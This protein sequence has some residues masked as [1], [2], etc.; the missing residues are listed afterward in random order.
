MSISDQTVPV[1]LRLPKDLYERVAHEA[2]QEQQRV[3][4]LLS[5]LVVAGLDAQATVRDLLEHVSTHYRTR[6]AEQGK[7]EQSGDE[8][9]DDLRTLREQIASELYP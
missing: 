8:V 1:T 4:D 6:L 2:D 5:M 3:D 9:L 7:L